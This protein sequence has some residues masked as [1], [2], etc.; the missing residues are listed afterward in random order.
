MGLLFIRIIGKSQEKLESGKP[1]TERP[2]GEGSRR[3]MGRV[4]RVRR[5][6]SKPFGVKLS[7]YVSPHSGHLELLALAVIV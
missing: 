3:P 2:C 6:S 1:D 5:F 4:E 7:P